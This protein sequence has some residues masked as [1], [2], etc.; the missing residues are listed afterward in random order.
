MSSENNKAVVRRFWEEM[1]G[2]G[3]LGVADEIFAPD[4]SIPGADE[5]G[6]SAAKDA[7][8]KYLEAF[9]S[10]VDVVIE[11]LVAT[12]EDKVVTRYVLEVVPEEINDRVPH[13]GIFI[14]RL[15]DGQIVESWGV[16]DEIGLL[17]QVKEKL[18]P[19]WAD[20]SFVNFVWTEIDALRLWRWW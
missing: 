3:D 8:R 10:K 20:D 13:R 6:P 12:E 7:I 17:R 15:Y 5:R 11:D 4:Y 1:V 2:G 19:E 14:S 18:P 9:D 16:S